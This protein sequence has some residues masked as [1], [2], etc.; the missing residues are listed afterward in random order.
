[1]TSI[2]QRLKQQGYDGIELF[3]AIAT[4]TVLIKEKS[5]SNRCPRCWHDKESRCI[6]SHIP[7]IIE[8]HSSHVKGVKVKQHDGL[9]PIKVMILMHYKEYLSAGNDAKLLLALLPNNNNNAQLY[10][11]GKEGEWDR[12]ETECAADPSHT[13][14]LWPAEDA[15]TVEEFMES[16]LP[17]DSPWR[18]QQQQQQQCQRRHQQQQAATSMSTT[19]T[20]SSDD[21]TTK[22]TYTLDKS[23]M[24]PTEMRTVS[25]YQQL[26]TLRVIVLDGVYSQARLMFRTIYR[27]FPSSAIPIP[28]HVALHPTTL[29]VYHRA[30]KSYSQSSSR[31]VTNRSKNSAALHICTVEAVALLMHELGEENDVTKALVRA[32]EINNLALVHS[33]DV[34]PFPPS[35]SSQLSP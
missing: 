5:R 18:R 29:S 34:R 12:F 9:L 25:S 33:A 3:E 16:N 27:R 28:S 2:S 19:K 24:C 17:N 15:L 11:F 26:P 35:S 20:T 30:Q 6:C 4:R 7:P 31:T 1:M 32:V 13:I 21:E 8:S 14:I 23:T 10:I 22:M